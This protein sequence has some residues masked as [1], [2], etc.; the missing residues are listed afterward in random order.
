MKSSLLGRLAR[1]LTRAG[2]GAAV[3]AGALLA[4]GY[5]LIYG[6]GGA[7]VSWDSGQIPF[8]IRMA[9]TPTL[10]DGSNYATSVLAAMAA[11]NAQLANVQFSGTTAGPGFAGE[12]DGVNEIAFDSEIYSNAPDG[13]EEF[14]PNVLAVTISYLTGTPRPDG[15]YAR[16]QSDVLF[17]TAWTWNSYRGSLQFPEDIRRVAIHELGH[18]LGLDHPDHGGQ[19][20]TAIMNSTVS[21]VD[22]LQVD[23]INGGQFLY[24]RPGGFS[25]PGNNSFA[26][27]IAVALSGPTATVTGSSIGANKESGEPYHAPDEPGGASVWWKWTAPSNGTLTV[28]TAGSPFDTMLGVYTG[29]SVGALSQLA[30]N[31]DAEPGVTRT[32]TAT[33]TVTGGT[34]YYFA[35]DGWDGQ[36]GDVRLNLTVT[37]A[38]PAIITQPTDQTIFAGDRASFSVTATGVPPP[39]YQWQR[40]GIHSTAWEDV[41][42]GGAYLGGSA[43]TLEVVG[44]T[45]MLGDRFRC[46]VSNAY[47]T[48]SSEDAMLI[49]QSRSPDMLQQPYPLTV[50]AGQAAQFS[51]SVSGVAPFTYQ[52]LRGG[53]AIDGATAASYS[54][55]RATL[56]DA[57]VYSVVVGNAYGSVTSDGATLT[58]NRLNQTIS[59]GTLAD[60]PFTTASISLTATASSG[61]PVGFSVLEGPASINGNNLT[62]SGAGRVTVRAFQGGD[63]IYF[64]APTIERSFDIALNLAAWQLAQFSAEELNQ[65][66]ISG[67]NADPDG[68]GLSNLLEYAL[69]LSPRAGST[70]PAVVSATDT[71]WGY[72]FNRPADRAD[73]TYAVE[74]STDLTTWSSDNVTLARVSTADGVE[75]WRATV[76]RTAG[77]NCFLRLR[78]TR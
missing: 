37:N 28:T 40:L 61:L 76:P 58:V 66:A 48:V 54:I 51:V 53:V 35:V 18:V 4:P 56:V 39:T 32:S 27:A 72:T 21:N 3:F 43:S 31:D 55:A 63:D 12:M 33:V 26:G 13:G 16:S 64:A 1:S 34:T 47:G 45:P 30:A 59:F 73:V 50:N 15:S 10:Q 9:Q 24:G 11:W 49:V 46:V 70:D 65:P 57:G 2:V 20:V 19:S 8:I 41:T 36:W 71:E 5:D 78:V 52:W 14:G 42:D 44:T 25:A 67:P 23:D 17:N 69:G 77:T 6:P 60:R 22:S 7:R 62:L 29:G 68:D 75:T 38:V 74:W